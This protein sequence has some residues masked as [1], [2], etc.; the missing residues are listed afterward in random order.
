[1]FG[2]ILKNNDENSI[3]EN[4]KHNSASKVSSLPPLQQLLFSEVGSICLRS[5]K[6]ESSLDPAFK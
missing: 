5:R 6:L 4:L 1:M 3:L 2:K